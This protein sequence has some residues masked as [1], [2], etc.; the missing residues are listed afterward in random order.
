MLRSTAASISAST[1]QGT[2]LHG[3]AMSAFSSLSPDRPLR[4]TSTTGLR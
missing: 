3:G 4:C 1:C 2:E